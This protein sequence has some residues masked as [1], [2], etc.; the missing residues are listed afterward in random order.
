MCR[1][2]RSWERVTS[3][4]HPSP[5]CRLRRLT[6][7]A[8]R[9][10]AWRPAR[11]IHWQIAR[12]KT[13]ARANVAAAAAT[14]LVVGVQFIARSDKRRVPTLLEVIHAANASA[15]HPPILRSLFEPMVVPFWLKGLHPLFALLDS[16]PWVPPGLVPSPSFPDFCHK[17]RHIAN[18][19]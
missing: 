9:D 1:D 19:K 13:S 7:R 14:E 3:H 16:S 4:V 11:G 8:A 10:A 18:P 12:D 6:A 15:S 17:V 5:P 2:C